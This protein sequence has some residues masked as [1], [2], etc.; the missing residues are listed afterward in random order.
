LLAYEPTPF[1]VFYLGSNHSYNKIGGTYA[2]SKDA[3]LFMKMQYLI[4]L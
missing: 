4:E 3:R 1:T 2:S